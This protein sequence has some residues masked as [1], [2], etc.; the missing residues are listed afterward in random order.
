MIDG[1]LY[2]SLGAGYGLTSIRCAKGLRFRD[3]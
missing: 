1:D 2:M 3:S